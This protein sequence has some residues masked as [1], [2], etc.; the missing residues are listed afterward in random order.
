MDT[1][2]EDLLEEDV[3]GTRMKRRIAIAAVALGVAGLGGTALA[4]SSSGG[5]S[6]F[7]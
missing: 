3:V 7:D 5:N 4:A 1:G 2:D 6:F